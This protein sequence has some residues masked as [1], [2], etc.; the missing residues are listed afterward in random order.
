MYVSLHDAAFWFELAAHTMECRNGLHHNFKYVYSQFLAVCMIAGK[1]LVLFPTARAPQ[2]WRAACAGRRPSRSAHDADPTVVALHAD[3]D[4]GA[5]PTGSP[6]RL[7]LG[8]A[9]PVVD[10]VP[11]VVGK[12][13]RP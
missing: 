5:M 4:S 7:A 9:P 2:A 11:D 1:A 8:D 13:E 6:L 12:F 10:L 3:E